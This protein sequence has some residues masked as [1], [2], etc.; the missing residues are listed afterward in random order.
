MIVPV[1]L[2]YFHFSPRTPKQTKPNSFVQIPH[3]QRQ[4]QPA[5]CRAVPKRHRTDEPSSRICETHGIIPRLLVLCSEDRRRG[6]TRQIENST[7]RESLQVV[8]VERD[9]PRERRGLKR[10]NQLLVPSKK[11]LRPAFV[12]DM[13]MHHQVRSNN[14]AAGR[15]RN[16]RPWVS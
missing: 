10:A 12:K 9:V 8:L 1:M 14:R 4:R 3:P 6:G 11:R 16:K 7:R 13:Q 2:Q 15:Q 5:A